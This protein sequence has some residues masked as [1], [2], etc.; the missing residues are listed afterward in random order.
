M[1]VLVVAALSSILVQYF[2]ISKQQCALA[3]LSLQFLLCAQQFELSALED[4]GGCFQVWSR[5]TVHIYTERYVL[6]NE[7]EFK[8]EQCE[9]SFMWI[10]FS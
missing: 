10:S 6:Q 7:Y 8:Q 3:S 2:Q 1:L 5:E 9:R 4:R